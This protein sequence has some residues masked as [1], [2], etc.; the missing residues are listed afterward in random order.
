MPLESYQEMMSPLFPFVARFC[1]SLSTEALLH[2]YFVK[3]ADLAIRNR[4]PKVHI[5][6]N[7]TL[8][9]EK[10][11]QELV[12]IGFHGLNLSLDA[13]K[14]RTFERLRK[15]A[16]FHKVIRNIKTLLRIREVHGSDLP[17][18]SCSFV[19]MKSNIHELPEFIRLNHDLGI[20]DVHI[21]HMVPYQGLDT[22]DE[23]L[24][25]DRVLCNRML[26]EARSLAET[27]GI[28]MIDPGDFPEEESGCES[29]SRMNE[30]FDLMLREEDRV[31]GCCPF[32]WHFLGIGANGDVK[33]CGWWFY[34]QPMGNLLTQSFEE[35]WKG[36]RFTELRENLSQGILP[37]NCECCPSAGMG[38]VANSASFSIRRLH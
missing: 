20:R 2:P 13:A 30:R 36:E 26:H 9:T 12:Q 5:S 18:M 16:R 17:Q 14:E 7:G 24:I 25:H 4:I 32:P 15:G 11:S 35:V 19:M 33:P 3:M 37:K 23:S 34:A 27:Y 1:L 8:L 29:K 28:N 31:R 6:T 22:G 21:M 38:H 10:L